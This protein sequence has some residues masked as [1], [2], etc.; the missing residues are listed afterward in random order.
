MSRHIQISLLVNSV[1]IYEN[2]LGD[3][4]ALGKES[5]KFRGFTAKVIR[6]EICPH[7]EFLKWNLTGK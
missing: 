2:R 5:V 3:V 1:V 7:E 4:F 6:A